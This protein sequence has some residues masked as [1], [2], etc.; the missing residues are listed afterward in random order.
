MTDP[1]RIVV[2]SDL[3]MGSPSRALFTAHDALANFIDH[4]TASP[5]PVELVILG[6]AVDFL[7]FD[8]APHKALDFTAAAAA[9][10]A[11]E[12]VAGHDDVFEALAGFLKAPGH[13][14]RWFVGNHDI[15]L[16]FEAVREVFEGAMGT[17]ASP[18]G[19]L[20]WH[21]DG[22]AHDYALCNGAHVRVRH[23][24]SADPWNDIDYAAAQKVADAGG[25]ANYPYPPGSR[26]VAGVIN[27]LKAKRFKHIDLLKPEL[28]VAIPLSLALWPA[29]TRSTC[30]RCSRASSRRRR[31]ARRRRLSNW[32]ARR[33]TLDAGA[34]APVPSGPPTDDDLL[35]AALHDIV[36]MD[37]TARAQNLADDL[38]KVLRNEADA[39]RAAAARKSDTVSR[40]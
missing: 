40:P 26:L 27:P 19:P 9:K 4:L 35:A 1:K 6:D 2:I 14:L 25:S 20:R 32:A 33:P 16:L 17:K 21:L 34:S 13:T 11:K 37:D 38:T 30:A 29:D 23:G 7:Q 39:K 24:N 5:A 3:H 22:E 8:E 28:T 31:R 18:A 12:I 15:E 10:K 36:V